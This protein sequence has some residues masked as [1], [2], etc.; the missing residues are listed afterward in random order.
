M[1]I[2]AALVYQIKSIYNGFAIAIYCT[3]KVVPFNFCS[4]QVSLLSES[5]FGYI[6]EVTKNHL[7]AACVLFWDITI[8]ETNLYTS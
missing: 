2:V 5:S 1:V 6:G 8:F 4:V 3:L 7:A